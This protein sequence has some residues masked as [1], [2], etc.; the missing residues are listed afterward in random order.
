M[1]SLHFGRLFFRLISIHPPDEGNHNT[2][3]KEKQIVYSNPKVCRVMY[4]FYAN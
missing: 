3:E 4:V 2:E 1:V